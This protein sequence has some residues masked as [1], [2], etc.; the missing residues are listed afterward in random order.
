MQ[1]SYKKIST[2][3]RKERSKYT[4]WYYD[5]LY[6]IEDFPGK[7]HYRNFN[8]NDPTHEKRYRYLGDILTKNFKFK[9]AL[10]AGCGMGHMMREL[11]HRDK[12]VKG[13]EVSKDAIKHFLADLNKKGLIAKAGLEKLPYKDGEFDLVFCSDVMEHIPMFDVPASIQELARVTK[14]YLVLTINLDHPYEYH[15]TIYS[16]PKWLQLFSK[17]KSLQHLRRLERKIEKK[18]KKKYCE[19]DWFI[20]KK[21]L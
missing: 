2:E 12:K 7:Q 18:T 9:T 3:R 16:R 21:V 5:N 13:V 10:D 6:W 17:N 11:L 15:P 19:Y 20:F 14:N 4:K 1:Q 8:Y